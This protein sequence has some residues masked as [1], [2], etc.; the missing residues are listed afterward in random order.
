MDKLLAIQVNKKRGKKHIS[1]TKRNIASDPKAKTENRM[2]L[3]IAANMLSYTDILKSTL[4]TQNYEK[5]LIHG[6]L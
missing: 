4:K 1:K 5:Q 6:S 3:T 2:W